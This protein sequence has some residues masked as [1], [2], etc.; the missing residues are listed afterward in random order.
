MHAPLVAVHAEALRIRR[1]RQVRTNRDPLLATLMA[2]RDASLPYDGIA[3]LWFQSREDILR[4]SGD[5]T[6]RDAARLL[7]EDEKRFIDTKRSPIFFGEE[8]E[9]FVA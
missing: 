6:A 5:A 4:N 8:F 2:G 9:V 3:E 7:Y 1:Y